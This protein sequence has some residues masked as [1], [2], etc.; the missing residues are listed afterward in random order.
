[1]FHLPEIPNVGYATNRAKETTDAI[2]F[3]MRGVERDRVKLLDIVIHGVERFVKIGRAELRGAEIDED[4]LR[5]VWRYFALQAMRTDYQQD[6]MRRPHDLF[7]FNNVLKR[8]MPDIER[9]AQA[10]E[11][12]AI[13]KKWS[14]YASA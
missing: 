12:D 4:V 8:A 13:R 11:E 14:P 9:Q 1:M 2:M 10:L 3:F 5:S 7:H 6:V